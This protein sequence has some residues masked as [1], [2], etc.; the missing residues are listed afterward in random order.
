MYHPIYLLEGEEPYFI[1]LVSDYMEKNIL[2]EAERSFNQTILY[3]KETTALDIRTRALNYPMFSNYQVIMVKE[4]QAL[5]KWDDLVGYFEKPVKSTILIICHKFENFDKRTKAAKEIQKNGVVLTTKKFYENQL[6]DFVNEIATEKELKL[7]PSVAN[8]LIEYIGNDLSRIANELEKLKLNLKGR[9]E[10]TL[11]DIEA[12]IGISK[13][14]NVFELNKAL[15][16]KDVL[17]ANRIV[18]YFTSNPKSNPMVLTLGA[19]QS[20]FSKVYLLHQNN[21]LPE[22]EIASVVGVMPFLLSEYRTA[23]RNYSLQ[24]VENVF[25]MLHEYDLRS[26]GVN[27]TG[28]KEGALLKE[29]VYKI[30]H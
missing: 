24:K 4:A 29:L 1:D 9:K 23:A 19:L 14:Y 20:Y 5:K 10:V 12:N 6:P 8:L 26:K 28:T 17:R 21:L 7:N 2:P 16:F 25:S 15:A 3:G 27:D 13:E 22:K 30:L 11:D 18:E